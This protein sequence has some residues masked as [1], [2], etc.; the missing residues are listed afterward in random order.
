MVDNGAMKRI[1]ITADEFATYRLAKGDVLFNRTNSIEHVG[2][3][4]LYDL[5]GEHT[6]ASYLVRIVP[7]SDEVLTEFL[8]RMMNADEFQSKAKAAAIRSINQ[9]NINASKMKRMDIPAPSLPDQQAA[10]DEIA[11]YEG[12][13]AAAEAILAAAPAGK[14]KILLDGIK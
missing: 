1:D 7:N 10:L 11:E 9:A 12:K 2:K 6:F 14:R 4:G 5:N 3:T 8:A 13:R